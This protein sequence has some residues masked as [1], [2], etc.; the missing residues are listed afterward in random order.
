M[1]PVPAKMF[2]LLCALSIPPASAR[3]Y[4]IATTEDGGLV[5]H[6]IHDAA[7]RI[8]PSA[9]DTYGDAALRAAVDGAAAAW[10]LP[11]VPHL[12]VSD[13][14]ASPYTDEHD[15]PQVGVYVAFGRDWI[16]DKDQLVM[17]TPVFND[18]SGHIQRANVVLHGD[19]DIRA[20]AVD[21][22]YDLQGVLTHELGHALGLLHSEHDQAVM[23]PRGKPGSLKWRTLAR[24]DRE[25]I[26]EAYRLAWQQDMSCQVSS[27]GA[28]L[29]R[30]GWIVLMLLGLYMIYLARR[31]D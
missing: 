5:V 26:T 18:D 6:W 3:A 16:W 7:I 30:H 28:R 17:T 24:D 1:T 15:A 2:L 10:A 4:D 19:K 22:S 20:D 13:W 11:G 12:L 27:P 23:W 25:G 9:S 21:D 31:R 14:P 8:S 29:Q